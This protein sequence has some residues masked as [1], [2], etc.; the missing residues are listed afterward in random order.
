MEFNWKKIELSDKDVIQGYY[1]RA[2]LQNCES[3]FANNYL[4][5]PHYKI[6]Y[7]PMQKTGN[8]S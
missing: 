5:A 2:K 1:R 3:T 4:W 8:F 7:T 6:R